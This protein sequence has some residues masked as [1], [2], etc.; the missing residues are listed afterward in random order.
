MQLSLLSAD[1]V[2]PELTDLGGLLAAHGQMAMGP[3]GARLSILLDDAWRGEALRRECRVRDIAVDLDTHD[4]RT[5][6]RSTWDRS[7]G[8]LAGQWRRGSAKWVPADLTISPGLLRCWALGAGRRADV[9]Y[10]LGLDPRA[11]EM[12]AELAS[13]CARAGLTASIVGLRT[14]S[15]ALRIVGYRRCTRLAEMLGTPPPESPEAFPSP[16]R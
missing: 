10:L 14:G 4:D 3:D 9:G 8:G 16:F 2:A 1:L 5:L 13:R 12:Y 11:P 15:P 6:L 7:L